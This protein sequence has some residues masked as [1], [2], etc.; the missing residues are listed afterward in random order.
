MR[1]LRASAGWRSPEPRRGAP[2]HYLALG[3]SY[4]IGEGVAEGNRWP[5]QLAAALRARGLPVEPPRIIATSGWTTEELS[6]AIDAAAQQHALLPRYDLV[7]L[8]IGV[9]D[10]YRGRA[11]DGYALAFRM[12]LERAIAFAD[13]QG[14][15]VLV[16]SIPDWGTTPFA[17]SSGRDCV[18]IAERIDA[19]NAVAAAVC[20][21]RGVAFI[22]VT[23]L[24]RRK[25]NLALL[26][27]DG[28]HPSAA[29]YLQ[30][31]A[32]LVRAASAAIA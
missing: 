15:R 1:R 27:D 30:W 7:T 8:G 28:L 31:V 20:A 5:V 22:D 4:T 9:N 16:P 25:D 24:G 10:Q 23:T 32:R 3:D 11:L 19:F 18:D 26:V 12:L 6:A 21:Q 13:G 14:R 2:V 29:L 17:R